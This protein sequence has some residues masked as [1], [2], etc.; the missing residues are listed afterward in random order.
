[1]R[2]R[3]LVLL[4]AVVFAIAACTGSD[5]AATTATHEQATDEP[6]VSPTTTDTAPVNASVT[7]TTEI[8]FAFYQDS[9]VRGDG[10]FTVTEGA[11]QLGCAEGIFSEQAVEPSRTVV[12]TMTCTSG[13]RAGDFSLTMSVAPRFEPASVAAAGSPVDWTITDSSDAF[14]GMTGGGEC[15]FVWRG[16]LDGEEILTGTIHLESPA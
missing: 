1:M 3:F 7:I 14:E 9:W 11:D 10:T 15:R 8:H 5:D 13:P 6:A 16:W 2:Q 12:K 4:T